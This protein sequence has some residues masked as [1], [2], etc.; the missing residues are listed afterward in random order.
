MAAEIAAGVARLE[1]M[2][3]LIVEDEVAI[4]LHICADALCGESDQVGYQIAANQGA[5]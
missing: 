4:L 5:L 2:A 3:L 1:R